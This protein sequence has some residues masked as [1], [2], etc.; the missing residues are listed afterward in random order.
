MLFTGSD[1]RVLHLHPT[2]RCNL[3][4]LH[5]YSESG[6]AESDTLGPAIAAST[7][8]GA[9]R[10]GYTMLSVSGGE[11]LMYP[12]LWSVLYEARRAGMIR[13]IV[14]NGVGLTET[15]AAR[16]RTTVDVV[17][18][19]LDG[20]PERHNR[21]RRHPGA[22]GR[23]RHG[24]ALLRAQQVRFKILFSVDADSLADLEWAAAFAVEHGAS[25]LQIHLIEPVGRAAFLPP[26]D[27]PDDTALKAFLIAQRLRQIWAGRLQVDVDVADLAPY[28]HDVS[29]AGACGS[30]AVDALSDVVSPLVLEP[31]GD[32]V[33][34]R[35]GFARAFAIGNIYDES[36]ESLARH[37]LARRAKAF[38]ALTRGA[39]MAAG[40]TACPFGNPYQIIADAAAAEVAPRV[41]LPLSAFSCSPSGCAT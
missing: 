32:V 29:T 8:A 19:S 14:T 13:A 3:T 33:P 38:L 20:R 11:P 2:R 25:A 26:D 28:A 10:L 17:A 23:L 12:G 34:L 31:N 27:S 6:P 1:L 24:L 37:W 7:V 16:L 21:L 36:I 41:Q 39:L 9:A 5:C 35:Y 4:C 40:R 30:V 18:V 22:F 15:I